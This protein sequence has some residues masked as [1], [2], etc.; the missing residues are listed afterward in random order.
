MKKKILVIDDEQTIQKVHSKILKTAGYDVVIASNGK[1]AL[2]KLEDVSVDLIMLDMKMPEM[3]G[4]DFLR[5]IREHD[6]THVP[7]LMVSGDDNP[8]NIVESY[9]LGVYDFIRKPEITDVMLKRVEN[10]LKIGEMINFNEFI[11]VE[12]LMARRLQKYLFPEPIMN[13][14]GVR[15][16]TWSLPL[17]DIGGDLYDYLTVRDGKL[18]FFVADVSGHSISAALYT[19]IV[20]MVFRNA[21]QNSQVPGEILSIMNKDLAGYIPVESFVTAFCGSYDSQLRTLEYANAGHPLP[22]WICGNE[23]GQLKGYDPFLGPIP[24]TSYSTFTFKVGEG[25][26]LF[27]YTDG[28]LDAVGDNAAVQAGSKMLF[29]ILNAEG[30][31]SLEK[32]MRVQEDITGGEMAATDDCTLMLVDMI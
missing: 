8:K 1:E 16:H 12:L 13:T 28:V 27:V 21:L 3:D 14:N 22:F 23:M 18:V 4:L 5:K 9:K 17:S 11:R 30:Q 31:S 15:I 26:S 7:V 6:I 2:D 19:A 25:T 20:K 29:S 32:F 24:D 10:G